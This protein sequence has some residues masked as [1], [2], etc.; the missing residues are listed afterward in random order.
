MEKQLSPCC[1]C[2]YCVCI[3]INCHHII[4]CI[5][6]SSVQSVQSTSGDATYSISTIAGTGNGNLKVNVPALEAKFNEIGG[7]AQSKN[8]DVCHGKCET[9]YSQI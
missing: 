1:Q 8:G 9:R 6:E 5:C 4:A 2:C 3:F 7:L